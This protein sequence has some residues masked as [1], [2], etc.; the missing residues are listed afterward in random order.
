MNCQVKNQ[1]GQNLGSISNVVVNPQTGHIR[2]AVVNADGKKV[3]VPWSALNFD[4]TGSDSGTPKC[5][6][7]TTKEKLSNAPKFDS[8][9]LASLS[10]RST[11]EPIYT[12]Y[13]L[14]YFPDVM[15]TQE[16]NARNNKSGSMTS[17][18]TSDTA[19]TT[20]SIGSMPSASASPGYGTTPSTNPT[21]TPHR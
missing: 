12:Y 9:N 19:V 1:Q 3:A 4:N 16:Q 15:T 17:S 5:T 21:S 2:Y 10:N 20:G 8:K 11:E 7:N 14:I 13:E 6:L 18:G